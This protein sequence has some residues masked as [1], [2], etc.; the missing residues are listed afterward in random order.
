M[1]SVLKH[2][3]ASS[4]PS[5]FEVLWIHADVGIIRRFYRAYQGFG[6]SGVGF[7]HGY[8]YSRGYQYTNV[9]NIMTIM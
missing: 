4:I 1:Y 9:D 5:V 7:H 6:M 8:Q 2:L 3:Q